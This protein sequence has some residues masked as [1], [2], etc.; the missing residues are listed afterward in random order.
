VVVTA[1][2]HGRVDNDQSNQK[3]ATMRTDHPHGCRCQP[4]LERR[5]VFEDAPG[6]RPGY[7]AMHG[8]GDHRW[9]TPAQA[10]RDRARDLDA[11]I[12]GLLEAE[13]D[14]QW[15]Q[16]LAQLTAAHARRATRGHADRNHAARLEALRLAWTARG[17]PWDGRAIGAADAWLARS[18]SAPAVAL[19]RAR[20]GGDAAEQAAAAFGMRAQGIEERITYGPVQVR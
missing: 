19:V 18:D 5:D 14:R 16:T 10:R 15:Q 6:P 3:G 8:I 2:P 1:D 20:L 4:C 17:I 9:P 13:R 12:G 7:F 11:W